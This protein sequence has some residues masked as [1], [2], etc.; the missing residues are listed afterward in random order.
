[1]ASATASNMIQGQSLKSN[2]MPIWELALL[3]HRFDNLK[4]RNMLLPCLEAHASLFK[5]LMKGIFEQM[6][7][8]V[9][10]LVG[11]KIIWYVRI[12]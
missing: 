11:L 3:V 8:V 4:K 5:L 12:L 1:M 10:S 7:Y 6:N 2:F 9:K